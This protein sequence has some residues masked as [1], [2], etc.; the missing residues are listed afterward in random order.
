MAEMLL[1]AAV[2]LLGII[3]GAGIAS[4]PKKGKDDNG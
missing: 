3:V 2:T 1:G 4:I